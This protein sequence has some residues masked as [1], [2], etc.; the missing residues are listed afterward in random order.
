MIFGGFKKIN[1]IG[2]LYHMSK[3]PFDHSVSVIEFFDAI[4]HEFDSVQ[5]LA[6]LGRLGQEKPLGT[7]IS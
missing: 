3:T 1:D 6:R 5:L 7:I 4:C 2:P